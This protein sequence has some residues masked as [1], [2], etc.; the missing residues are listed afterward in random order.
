MRNI[1]FV[2]IAVLVAASAMLSVYAAD[3]FGA[4]AAKTNS[5]PTLQEMLTYALQDEYLAYT[6]YL[7]I[8]GKHGSIRPFSNIVQAEESHIGLLL[9]LFENYGYAVPADNSSEYIVVPQDIKTA[10]ET[11]VQAEIDNIAMYE[12]F[13]EKDI[14]LDVR[15]VF[16]RL[17]SA[18]ENHL[19]AFQNGLKRYQ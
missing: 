10:L 18:S 14:P 19:R 16:Q 4:G 8:I 9:P 15:E 12:S 13:L 17:K 2:I 3:D 7:R 5:D 1:L 6:E 11:G